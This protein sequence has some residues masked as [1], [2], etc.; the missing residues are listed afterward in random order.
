MIPNGEV[1][2]YAYLSIR[3]PEEIVILNENDFETKCGE[4]L[5]GFTNK[6]ISCTV[7]NGGRTILIKDGFINA[8]TTNLTDSDGLYFPP[9]IGFTLDKF[10]NP[11]TSGSTGAWNVTI[12]S[13][14]DK[15][16]Y[17]WQ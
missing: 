4:S 1:E 15:E 6:I 8:G 17:F 16:L 9:D 5:Y 13:N 11:R 7:T 14:K 3:L 10:Q 12:L 2:R